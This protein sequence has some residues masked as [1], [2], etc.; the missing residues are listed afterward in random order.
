MITT[1]HELCTHILTHSVGS[2]HQDNPSLPIK[3]RL[4][5]LRKNVLVV[6]HSYSTGASR[7]F[8]V[9]VVERDQSCVAA[10]LGQLLSISIVANAANE[11]NCTTTRGAEKGLRNAATILG[12]TTS[13]VLHVLVVVDNVFVNALVFILRKAGACRLEIVFVVERLIDVGRNIQQW[14]ADSQKGTRLASLLSRHCEWVDVCER[15]IQ[16]TI[17]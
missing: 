14:V 4:K 11:A 6:Q 17:R 15:K 8:V 3:T 10:S 13:N 9:N 1:V 2:F 12:G 16:L 5:R 7:G